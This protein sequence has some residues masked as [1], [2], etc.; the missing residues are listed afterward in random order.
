MHP[1]RAGERP[2]PA[3]LNLWVSFCA[4]HSSPSSTSPVL[5]M[6]VLVHYSHTTFSLT[7]PYTTLCLCAYHGN[8]VVQVFRRRSSQPLMLCM[9]ELE[10][11]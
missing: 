8:T 2:R 7:L 6:R 11:W 9:K 5:Q 3:P 10:C 4:N 1:E